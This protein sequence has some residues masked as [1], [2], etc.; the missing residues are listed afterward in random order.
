MVHCGSASS[1]ALLG[2]LIIAS[3][4]LLVSAVFGALA[5]WIQNPKKKPQYKNIEG[6]ASCVAA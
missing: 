3:P 6:R 1:Q 2:F 4:S 5:V